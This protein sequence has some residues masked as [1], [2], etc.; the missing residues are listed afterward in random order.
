MTFYPAQEKEFGSFVRAGFYMS[1]AC[2]PLLSLD[3]FT[4]S[5]TRKSVK[6]SKTSVFTMSLT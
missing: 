4:P 5:P 1:F 2:A 6:Y 3:C